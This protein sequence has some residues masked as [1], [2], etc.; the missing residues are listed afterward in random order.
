MPKDELD[1]DKEE[2]EL[3]LAHIMEILK[4]SFPEVDFSDKPR[5]CV[6]FKGYLLAA[7]Q[8]YSNHRVILVFK[9]ALE[10]MEL[11]AKK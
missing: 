3:F 11:L 8:D 10:A 4:W 6:K 7:V 2:M 5:A 9:A 1:Y